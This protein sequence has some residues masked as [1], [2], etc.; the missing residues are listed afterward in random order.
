[1]NKS[2][3]YTHTEEYYSSIKRRN[4]VICERINGLNGI[5]GLYSKWNK[6]ATHKKYH[7]ISLL[8]KIKTS[9]SENRMVIA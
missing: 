2:R 8:L 6:W 3:T 9:N 5:G 7:I 4:S 1:M